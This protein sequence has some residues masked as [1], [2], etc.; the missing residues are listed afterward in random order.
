MDMKSN[1]FRILESVENKQKLDITL[2]AV[3]GNRISDTLTALRKCMNLM[4]FAKVKFITF[5][6]PQNFPLDIEYVECPKL[7]YRMYTEYIFT[8]LGQHID[9]S[10]CLLIQYDSW[11]LRPQ[12]WNDDWLQYDYVAP[13]WPTHANMQLPSGEFVRVGCGGFSL[14]SRKLMDIPKKYNL[15]LVEYV[16][17]PCNAWAEDWNSCFYYRNLYLEFGIKYAPQMVATEFGQEDNMDE[18]I[19]IY[20]FGFHKYIH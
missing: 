20:P 16:G 5:E 3:A 13:P 10:H 19:G 2:V 1:D 6:R 14:R 8:D 17:P 11:I 15:P 12:M 4:D 18:N 7:N 9:T